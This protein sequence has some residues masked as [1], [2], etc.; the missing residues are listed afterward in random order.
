MVKHDMTITVIAR[1]TF[2]EAV[3]DRVLYLLLFF[4]APPSSFA[5]S[6]PS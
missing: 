3:R 4:A 6:W 1:N 2:K 5:G